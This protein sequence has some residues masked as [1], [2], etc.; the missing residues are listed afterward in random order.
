MAAS[1][2]VPEASNGT[3]QAVFRAKSPSASPECLTHVTH[4]TAEFLVG[5]ENDCSSIHS[6]HFSP[7]GVRSPNTRGHDI[8]RPHRCGNHGDVMPPVDRVPATALLSWLRSSLRDSL[9]PMEGC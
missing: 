3:I 1:G 4:A 6:R 8:D 9:G 5:R 7:V 2:Q